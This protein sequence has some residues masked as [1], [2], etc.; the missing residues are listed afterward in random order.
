M[1]LKRPARWVHRIW[2]ALAVI[3][4]SLCQ[5]CRREPGRAEPPLPA[6]HD[7]RRAPRV[8]RS[9][10]AFT[11]YRNIIPPL[12]GN[13]KHLAEL[14]VTPRASVQAGGPVAYTLYAYVRLRD[15]LNDACF[16][17]PNLFT[18]A[19]RRADN[20]CERRLLAARTWYPSLY[21]CRSTFKRNYGA[22]LVRARSTGSFRY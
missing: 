16:Q 19:V 12:I 17:L 1:N 7:A 11:A 3:V 4:I 21:I 9:Y 22:I 14:E 20:E 5:T 18:E 10:N 15:A 8:Y 13:S 2:Y 6:V